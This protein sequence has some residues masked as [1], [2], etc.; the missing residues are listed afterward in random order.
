MPTNNVTVGR[1]WVQ[2]TADATPTS[3]ECIS[4]YGVLRAA[5]TE[6]DKSEMLGHRLSSG[7]FVVV[8]EPV[9]AR[10]T[11]NVGSL[12]LVVT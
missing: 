8:T 9:Y 1:E 11:A 10:S 7:D 12:I 4:G 5:A 2:L 6:P 3:I